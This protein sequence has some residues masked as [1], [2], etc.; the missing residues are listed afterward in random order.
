MYKVLS[1]QQLVKWELLYLWLYIVKYNWSPGS[2]KCTRWVDFKYKW[3]LEVLFMCQDSVKIPIFI[4]YV[5]LVLLVTCIPVFYL[6]LSSD[7]LSCWIITVK[8]LIHNNLAMLYYK[9][10]M[11]NVFMFTVLYR[12][13]SWDWNQ[14][15]GCLWI[16]LTQSPC[17]YWC[18]LSVLFR[19][20]T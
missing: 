12:E 15:L 14:G 19:I 1:Q 5:V 17:G 8:Y 10:G 6:P 16:W 3:V 18:P 11:F 20:I 7:I 2:D 4:T 9:L 13:I